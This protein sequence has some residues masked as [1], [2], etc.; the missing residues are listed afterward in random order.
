MGYIK[1]IEDWNEQDRTWD[2][3]E[4]EFTPGEYAAM[5]SAD[6]DGHCGT[7]NRYNKRYGVK[8]ADSSVKMVMG[9]LAFLSLDYIKRMK[10]WFELNRPDKKFAADV[11]NFHVYTFPEGSQFGDSGPA[12]S[13]EAG[14]LKEQ[15]REIVE[16]RNQNL[17]G[18]EIWVSE[19]GWDL[20][21]DSRLSVPEIG[22]MDRQEVQGI[23]LVRA[24]MALAAAGVDRAQMYMLRDVNPND[25][26]QFASSGLV[27]PKGDLT[28]KKSWYY[29]ATLKKLLTNMRF[30]GEE[31]SSD[32]NILVYKFKD[33]KSSR[34]V[35]AVWAKTSK[36]YKADNFP[37][38]VSPGV[39]QAQMVSLLAG[40]LSGR[41]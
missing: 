27:G 14:R 22:T 34:G 21:P 24:Y 3:K 2:G 9:G 4:A 25:K 12:L 17:P 10:S 28:P 39:Q 13:P 23:W 40:S 30:L 41:M 38:P 11:L 5:A 37:L 8:N 6:Y 15:L 1:Y 35:Y 26:T 32:P 36:D 20:H 19:F 29:I 33:I 31:K 7:M 18:K 16:Y